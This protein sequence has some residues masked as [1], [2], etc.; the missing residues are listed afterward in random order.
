MCVPEYFK[1]VIKFYEILSFIIEVAQQIQCNHIYSKSPPTSAH[2]PYNYLHC[3]YR[4]F[5]EINEPEELDQKCL[6][7]CECLAEDLT[8]YNLKVSY[9]FLFVW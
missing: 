3:F 6:E 5:S 8:K 1:F 4:T 9:V 7:L 2:H